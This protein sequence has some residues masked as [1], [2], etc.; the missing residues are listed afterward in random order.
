MEVPI[1]TLDL[2]N[3]SQDEQQENE[4]TELDQP[5]L[6]RK[7]AALF[8]NVSPGTLAIWD[9]MKAVRPASDESGQ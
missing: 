5:L 6:D 4:I 9:C 7:Q 2:N 3:Q 8:L 1:L